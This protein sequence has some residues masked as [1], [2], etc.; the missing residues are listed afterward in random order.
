MNYCKSKIKTYLALSCCLW[1]AGPAHA[2]GLS[3]QLGEVVIQNLQVGQAYNLRDLANLSLSVVNRGDEEIA[4]AMD[5]LVPEASELKQGAEAIPDLSWI[6]L[7]SREHIVSAGGTATSDIL[8]TIPDDDHLLG[9]KFQVTVWSH[10]VPRP[11]AGM[12][13]AYGLKSRII[14]TVDPVR[15]EQV[16]VV[17]SSAADAGCMIAP[18]EIRVARVTAGKLCDLEKDAGVLLTLSNP[19]SSPRRVTLASQAVSAS[20]AALPAGYLDTPDAS[21]LTFSQNEITVAPGRSETVRMFLHFPA[22]RRYRGQKYMFIINAETTGQGV[23]A[24][25]YS[26]LYASVE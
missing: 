2:G 19:G 15:A 12:A 3:T 1:A 5:P 22:E 20:Q 13:L 9:R 26:R 7:S 23:K 14:F 11:G 24:G 6:A 10:S 17:T 21:Y 16:E 25:V 8:V 18:H 4:L